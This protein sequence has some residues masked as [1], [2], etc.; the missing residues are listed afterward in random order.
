MANPQAV[1]MVVTQGL[2][3]LKSMKGL[4]NFSNRNMD[5]ASDDYTRFFANFHSF[6]VYT[7]M[8]SEVDENEHVQAFQQQVLTFDAPYAPLRVKQPAEVNAKESKALY[9]AA[10]EAYNKMV[11]DLG[12]AD[13]VVNPSFL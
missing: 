6:D 11:T 3:V 2:N 7:H 10:V 4:W 12:K 9:E 5:K 13:K 8:D 1:E